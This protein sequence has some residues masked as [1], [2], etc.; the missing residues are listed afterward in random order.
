MQLVIQTLSG[1]QVSLNF[2][3]DDT[4]LT[5]KQTLQEKEGID[6]QMIKLIQ[7][8]KQLA[9]ENKIKDYNIEA[10]SKIHMILQLRG[11]AF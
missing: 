7:G 10:G 4:I 6:A 9:D 1:N 11:G 2:E 8:G 3:P 5:M